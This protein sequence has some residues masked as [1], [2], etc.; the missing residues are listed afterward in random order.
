MT[1]R[2]IRRQNM[3]PYMRVDKNDYGWSL[4][5][6]MAKAS[7]SVFDDEGPFA[8]L[9]HAA[10]LTLANASGLR[11]IRTLS[12][13]SGQSLI[14][15]PSVVNNEYCRRSRT[16]SIAVCLLRLRVCFRTCRTHGERTPRSRMLNT[17]AV[18]LQTP[19][20]GSAALAVAVQQS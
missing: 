7:L 12:S 2:M 15:T 9:R 17:D 6:L 16:R 8:A 11:D 18:F 19:L 13:P 5:C 4:H 1:L 3:L 10:I 14:T 20:Y